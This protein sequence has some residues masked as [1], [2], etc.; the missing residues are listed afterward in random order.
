MN[1]PQS[2][3]KLGEVLAVCNTDKL[4]NPLFVGKRLA[5]K[6]Y[7]ISPRVEDLFYREKTSDVR[8]A[9]KTDI[10]N[11]YY[12]RLNE[13]QI[14]LE[15][16]FFMMLLAP[17]DIF[18]YQRPEFVSFK[19]D[20]QDT[21]TWEPLITDMQKTLFSLMDSYYSASKILNTPETMGSTSTEVK[22]SNYAHLSTLVTNLFRLGFKYEGREDWFWNKDLINMGAMFYISGSKSHGPLKSYLSSLVTKSKPFIKTSKEDPKDCISQFL[23]KN[24]IKEKN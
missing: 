21:I 20:F 17:D 18:T 16:P 1:F 8:Y 6:V 9:R 10:D 7:V 14:S 22:D 4:I 2:V 13:I 15:D 24:L 11:H 5:E 23:F 12:Q 19:K 3:I